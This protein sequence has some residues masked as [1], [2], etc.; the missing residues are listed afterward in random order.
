MGLQEATIK[1]CV[2]ERYGYTVTPGRPGVLPKNPTAV[3]MSSSS[4]H[5]DPKAT[6]LGM[7][8][9]GSGWMWMFWGPMAAWS[10]DP[11]S[12][13]AHELGHGVFHLTHT[14]CGLMYGYAGAVRRT[15][16]CLACGPGGLPSSV[17]ELKAF[18][19]AVPPF[20]QCEPNL[21]M[22]FPGRPPSVCEP[23]ERPPGGAV[24]I[25]VLQVELLGWGPCQ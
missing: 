15:Q 18:G 2:R 4:L 17:R 16:R 13:L 14:W 22:Y 21:A 5:V 9:L 25:P 23:E 8:G 20:R 7:S 10:P 11:A 3:W 6:T 1:Q 19:I 12:T 24:P